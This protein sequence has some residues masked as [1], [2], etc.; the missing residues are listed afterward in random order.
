M[1]LLLTL[2]WFI[3]MEINHSGFLNY[4]FIGEHFQRF[5]I[6]GWS[7]DKYGF[8]HS[9]PFFTILI[10]FVICSFQWFIYACFICYKN[11]KQISFK[12]LSDF[13]LF[14]LLN[15]IVPLIF[16]SFSRNIIIPYATL[17]LVSFCILIAI[18]YKVNFKTL[19]YLSIPFSLIGLVSFT[20]IAPSVKT[21]DKILVQEFNNQNKQNQQTLY[22]LQKP[23][24][25]AY[26][27]AKDN[28]TRITNEDL[29]QLS[30]VFFVSSSKHEERKIIC[31]KA[32]CLYKK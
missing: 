22:Y 1:F 18:N 2:P 16:F 3:L 29:K 6:K 11:R 10:F 26:F 17:S 24:F 8:A 21:S 19:F 4:F 28:I 20:V 9:E 13:N 5:L 23:D 27:Y 12:N 31:N 25:N 7:G 15:F 32:R 14:T 30:N